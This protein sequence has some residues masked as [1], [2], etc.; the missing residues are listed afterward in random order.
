MFSTKGAHTHVHTKA[1][2]LSSG[3]VNLI[4]IIVLQCTCISNHVVHFKYAIEKYAISF[5]NSTF[6]ISP[7]HI[8]THTIEGRLPVL[9]QNI[10][11]NN[12][13]L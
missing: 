6:K 1:T 5:V 7:H 8:H 13:I 10:N 4:V 3:C 9:I 12:R 11:K 2:A